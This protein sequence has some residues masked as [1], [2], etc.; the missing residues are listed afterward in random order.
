MTLKDLNIDRS[1]TLFLD[2]DGVINEKLD[3]DYVKRWEEFR[4]LEGSLEAVAAL[5]RLFG[6][7]VVVTNQQGIGKWLYT[8]EALEEIHR[9]MVEAIVAQGGR[10]D[11]VYFSPYLDAEKHP[12]RKP[13]T[14]MALQAKMDFPEIE[15]KK[16]VMVGDSMSDMKFGKAAG[17]QTAFISPLPRKDEHIDF[18][19][20]SLLQFSQALQ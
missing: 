6:K 2:R 13:A 20:A 16:S 11:R 9:R 4:F 5:S 14:G 15:F 18:N 7:I 17:M 19:F 10:I 8:S 3:N 12:S 1:W